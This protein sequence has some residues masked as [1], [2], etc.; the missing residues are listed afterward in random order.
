M[1][2]DPDCDDE[3]VIRIKHEQRLLTHLLAYTGDCGLR[4]VCAADRELV[5]CRDDKIPDS[6]AKLW[7]EFAEVCILHYDWFQ[8]VETKG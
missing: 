4:R 3:V 2:K 8:D 1:N 5:G 6:V 7:R